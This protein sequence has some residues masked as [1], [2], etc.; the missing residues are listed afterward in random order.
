MSFLIVAIPVAVFAL[1]GLLLAGYGGW[2]SVF[3]LRTHRLPNHHVAL[4]TALE[5][6]IMSVICVVTGQ[7]SPFWSALRTGLYASM[8]FLVIYLVSRRQLGMG[9]VKY[10]FPSGLVVGF[11]A[12][13]AWLMWIFTS[14]LLAGLVSLIGML[15]GKLHRTSR[16]AFGPYMTLASLAIVLIHAV[17]SP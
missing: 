5:I 15:I 13:T 7:W 17:N 6:A 4:L 2:L 8:F 9:D 12:P 10:A 3:D 14:F 11:Y 1:P 16:I